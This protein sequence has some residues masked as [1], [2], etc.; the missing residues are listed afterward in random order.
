MVSVCIPTY[1]GAKYI[2]AQL[3]SILSQLG[4][5][6]EVIISDDQLLLVR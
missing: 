3:E 5:N 1:N 2:K 6:D 4:I